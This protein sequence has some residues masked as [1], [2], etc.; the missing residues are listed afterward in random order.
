L[1]KGIQRLE[2]TIERNKRIYPRYRLVTTQGNIF[3]LV[4]QNMSV[5]GSAHYAI[6]LNECE[7]KRKSPGFLGKVRSNIKETEYN[8]FGP[9]ENPDKGLPPDQIR[10]QYG[11]VYYVCLFPHIG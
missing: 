10:C 4:A 11:A 9:G 1:A 2:C 8:L 7:I 3:L 6:T 5:V